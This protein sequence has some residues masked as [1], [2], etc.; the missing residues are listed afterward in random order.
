MTEATSDFGCSRC[1]PDTPEAAWAARLEHERVAHLIAESH[2]VVSILRCLA[3]DQHFVSI[4]TETIDWEGGNDP[5]YVT[6]MPLTNEEA[7]RL[8]NLRDQLGEADLNALPSERRSLSQNWPEY[9]KESALT[10]GRGV[11]VGRHD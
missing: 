6:V 1:W 10:W 8:L 5:Q 9:A 7:A 2:F 3:C 4:F 11:Y